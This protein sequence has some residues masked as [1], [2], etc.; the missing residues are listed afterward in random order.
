MASTGLA[1]V[2]TGDEQHLNGQALEASAQ[3]PAQRE[4][5]PAEDNMIEEE[6]PEQVETPAFPAARLPLTSQDQ[7]GS[8]PSQAGQTADLTPQWG[9]QTQMEAPKRGR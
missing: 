7:P 8:H 2:P 1:G 6:D 4:D 5:S 9:Q 3:V